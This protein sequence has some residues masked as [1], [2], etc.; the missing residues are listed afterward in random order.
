VRVQGKVGVARERK[1]LY[2][3]RVEQFP[4]LNLRWGLALSSNFGETVRD[5]EYKDDEKPV[6]GAFD[7]KVA[8]ERVGTEQINR[9]V[10]DIGLVGISYES[11]AA[12]LGLDGKDGHVAHLAD[13]GTFIEGRVI[14]RHGVRR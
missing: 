9:L 13:V 5:E 4:G 1:G 11:W 2:S 10:E 6:S 8:E 12:D 7:L 14:G 3:E